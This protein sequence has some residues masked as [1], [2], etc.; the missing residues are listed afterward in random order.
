MFSTV[1]V[2]AA[3][4]FGGCIVFVGYIKMGGLL[5][6]V[7]EILVSLCKVSCKNSNSLI[8]ELD[9]DPDEEDSACINSP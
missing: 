5:Y 8:I 9:S 6:G 4:M 2:G 3:A 1:W 7:A